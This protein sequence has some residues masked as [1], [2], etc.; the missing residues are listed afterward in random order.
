MASTG[1]FQ[2]FP[3]PPPKINTNLDPNP[4]RRAKS[5]HAAESV[6]FPLQALVKSPDTG[7]VIM[8]VIEGPRRPQPFPQA[9]IAPLND[10]SAEV[11]PAMKPSNGTPVNASSSVQS[12]PQPPPAPV[13]VRSA[14]PT[15]ATNTSPPSE[16]Q[17][18]SPVVPMRSM[19]PTY[20]PSLPLAQQPYYPQRVTSLHGQIASRE[21][22]SPRLAS[23]SQLDEVLGGAKTA[24]SSVLDFPM[25][26]AAPKLPTFSS[27]QDLARLWEATNGQEPDRVAS[28]FDLQ[29]SRYLS[30]P[31]SANVMLTLIASSPPPSPSDPVH[32]FHFTPFR[33]IV[34]MN[35]AFCA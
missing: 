15:L 8:Q 6:S 23:P 29:M 14:S 16:P 32:H 3:P 9:R 5:K 19:F 17:A 31:R 2:L 35:S 30:F 20:N 10:R 26:D 22:Y 25:D 7:A 12:L 28:G 18:N 33:H 1:H 34:P 13:S 21:E 27:A 4:F 24:P 11:D